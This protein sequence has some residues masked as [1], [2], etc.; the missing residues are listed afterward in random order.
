MTDSVDLSPAHRSIVE[1][2]L[3]EYVPECEVRAFGSRVT[4]TARDS[5]DLDLAIVGKGPL[6][7][8]MLSRLNEAF[9]ESPLPMRIDV[10]DWHSISQSFREVIDRV[11]EV[12]QEQ[13]EQEESKDWPRVAISEVIDFAIGGGWGKETAFPDSIEVSVIRGTDF[14]RISDGDY[15]NIPRRF[16]KKSKVERRTLKPGDVILEISGGSRKSNQSTGRS[17]LVSKRHLNELGNKVIPASF[18]RLLRFDENKVDPVFAYYSLQEMYL[19]GRAGL[20]EHQSTGISNFQFSYFRDSEIVNLPPLPEQ[21]AIA[22]ILG[23]LDDKIEL[24]RRMNQ[25]LEEKARALFKS[26]FVDFDPVRARVGNH[27]HSDDSVRDFNVRSPS[28]F[29]DRFVR[30][31]LGDIPKGWRVADIESICASIASGGTPARRNPIYWDSGTIP[32]YKT[33]EL[34]DGPLLQSREKITP[35]AIDRSSA[36]LWPAGTI[37]FALYAS[38]TVG[39]IGVLTKPGASNQAAAGLVAKAD[40]GVPFL[41]RALISVR[42]E[43]QS[44]AVGAAQ[45]NISQTILRRH[46]LVVP[47]PTLARVYSDLVAPIDELQIL[48]KRQTQTLTDIRDVLLV[49]L[50]SGRITV[51][52]SL[53]VTVKAI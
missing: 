48:L 10:V 25:T 5:S 42:E 8:R 22:H 16:E 31:E 23:T 21:R 47:N 18:C 51:D 33:G 7:M 1:R 2:I 40:Y 20:Y 19:S 15:K 4:W 38:P 6:D 35:I 53:M 26:W 28:L 46:K 52:D 29:P 13:T 43:L 9:E 14:K 34:L 49:H 32:W 39:R 27:W 11:Y 36:K 17:F 44:I 30:S 3:V 50:I 12:V 24:N 41:R 45:Q 37:L